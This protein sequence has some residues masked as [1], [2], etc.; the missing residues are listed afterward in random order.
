L[1][2]YEWTLTPYSGSS[3]NAFD[4]DSTGYLNAGIPS[5]SA[6]VRPVGYLVSSLSVKSGLGTSSSPWVIGT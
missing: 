4:L 6:A 2:T 3:C 1:E 5:D